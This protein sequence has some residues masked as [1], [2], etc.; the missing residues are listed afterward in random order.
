MRSIRRVLR[1]A[2]LLLLIGATHAAAAR[3]SGDFAAA[4]SAFQE[5]LDQA[6]NTPPNPLRT[7]RFRA[8][9][10]NCEV[11]TVAPRLRPASLRVGRQTDPTRP[12]QLALKVWVEL[13]RPDGQSRAGQFV[14]LEQHA[15]RPSQP[16]Y[17]WFESATP[18]HIALFQINNDAATATIRARLVL[19]SIGIPSSFD[20]LKPGRRARYPILLRTDSDLTAEELAVVACTPGAPFAGRAPLPIDMLPREPGNTQIQAAMLDTCQQL[21][22]ALNQ[23]L[24]A[25]PGTSQAPEAWPR[26]TRSR[27]TVV[28]PDRNDGPTVD[29]RQVAP[30]LLG[31]ELTAHA[32]FTLRKVP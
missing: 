18:V 11:L 15:W 3:G 24:A 6:R 1:Y 29:P 19:P 14:S 12:V 2:A 20:T 4:E 31:S 16:F 30:I 22:T 25:R 10:Q 23:A 7:V 13:V 9:D 26:S 21:E 5:L 32:R 28:A 17:L 27:F 8:G